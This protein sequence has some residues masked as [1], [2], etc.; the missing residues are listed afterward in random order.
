MHKG[1]RSLVSVQHSESD[2]IQPTQNSPPRLSRHDQRARCLEEPVVPENIAPNQNVI[3]EDQNESY[4]NQVIDETA[5]D[6]DDD[7]GE[8]VDNNPCGINIVEDDSGSDLDIPRKRKNSNK[9]IK[10]SRTNEFPHETEEVDNPT[11][12][13]FILNAFIGFTLQSFIQSNH[14]IEAFQSET[15]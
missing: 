11:T 8:E 2:V 13:S 9:F 7:D 15:C 12:G 5:N 6:D 4:Q 3:C 1:N 14:Q 10:S